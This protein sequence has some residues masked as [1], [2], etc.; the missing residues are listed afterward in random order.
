MERVGKGRRLRCP[1]QQQAAVSEERRLSYR[2]RG[3]SDRADRR[4]VELR[5]LQN[6]DPLLNHDGVLYWKSLHDML[7]E[8]HPFFSR[9]EKRHVQVG[10]SDC[11]RHAREATTRPNIDK[12]YAMRN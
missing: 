6:L 1:Y 8:L 7:E 12:S 5:V 4:D 2:C 10:T 9:F 11:E 3:L